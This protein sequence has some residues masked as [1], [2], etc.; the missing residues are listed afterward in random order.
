MNTSDYTFEP[1][2]LADVNQLVILEQS[3]F[4]TDH[5]SRKNLRYLIQ[6][7]TVIVAKTIKTNEIIGFAIVLGRKNSRKKR[8]YALGVTTATRNTG[9]GSQLLAII[10]NI[11]Q[12]TACTTL[13]LEVNDRNKAAITFYNRCGFKQYGFRY[14]YY[15]DGGHA[16][17]MRKKLT[18]SPEKNAHSGRANCLQT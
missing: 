15:R 3:L 10:E 12:E 11:S 13:T 18:D 1:A 2:T 17:L 7:G 9:I 14:C 8:I 6:R 16:L 4:M 5:C